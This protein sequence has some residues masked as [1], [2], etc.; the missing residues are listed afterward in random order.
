LGVLNKDLTSTAEKSPVRQG[1]RI[2][3]DI[4]KAAM[5]ENV[6]KK[7]IETCQEKKKGE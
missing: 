3:Q 5:I 4:F 1:Q 7:T 6:I 2:N